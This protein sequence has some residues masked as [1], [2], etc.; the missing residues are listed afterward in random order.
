MID[1][2]FR[3][4]LRMEENQK[5][6]SVKGSPLKVFLQIHLKFK[7]AKERNKNQLLIYLQLTNVYGTLLK[8]YSK[9]AFYYTELFI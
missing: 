9:F 7:I 4:I 2:F 5:Y 8:Y 6:L 1:S 3:I